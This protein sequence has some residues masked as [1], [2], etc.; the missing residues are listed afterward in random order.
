MLNIFLIVVAVVFSWLAVIWS[1]S[2]MVNMVYKFVF[3]MLMSWSI[4]L[5]L[6]QYGYII[7]V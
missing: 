6:Q 2:G 1:K 7:K 4:F 5:V 3:F